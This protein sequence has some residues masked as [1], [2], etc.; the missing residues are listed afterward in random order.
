[1][2]AWVSED[3]VRDRPRLSIWRFPREL[4]YLQNIRLEI[5]HGAAPEPALGSGRYLP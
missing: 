5:V 1:M 2:R 3:A 4:D